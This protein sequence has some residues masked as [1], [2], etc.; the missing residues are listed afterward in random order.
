MSRRP[1]NGP[2]VLQAVQ[3]TRSYGQ[4]K[5]VN[6]VDVAVSAGQV[7]ALVGLNGAGNKSISPRPKGAA[8][9][10]RGHDGTPAARCAA[11]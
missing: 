7:C 10:F 8:R 5:A 3:L 6:R 2:V 11:I 9:A 4:T 1:S